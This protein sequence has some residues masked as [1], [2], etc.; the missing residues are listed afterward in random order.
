M[1]D[2]LIQHYLADPEPREASRPY[3]IQEVSE[4]ASPISHPLLRR[5]PPTSVLSEMIKSSPSFI[6]EENGINRH[7]GNVRDALGIQTVT[8]CRRDTCQPTERSVLLPNGD[9]SD[10]EECAAYRSISNLESQKSSDKPVVAYIRVVLKRKTAR[11]HQLIVRVFNLKSRS[12][13]AAW[14]R[15]F[16]QPINCVPPV[17]LGLLLNILDALSY[18]K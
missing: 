2:H 18:G 9:V 1:E 11:V 5:P 8:S 6:D 7:E 3:D 17:F 13:Q 12:T 14:I 16:R 10:R 4:P 15:G